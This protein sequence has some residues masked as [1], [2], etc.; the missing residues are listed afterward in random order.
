[1]T[2]HQLQEQLL[3]AEIPAPAG[4]WEQ[5]NHVLDEDAGDV[6]FQSKLHSSTVTVPENVW[7][8]IE[9][10][11]NWQQQDETIAVSLTAQE[12]QPPAFIWE[13]LET[14][15]N[16]STEQ[17]LAEKLLRAEAE[18]PVAVWPS[19]EKTLHSKAKV[20]P[21][22]KRISSVFRY[23]AAAV[24][25]GLIAWGAFLFLNPSSQDIAVIP[26]TPTVETPVPLN[27]TNTKP[28]ATASIEP[29]TT[30]ADANSSLI[31]Y[32]PPKKRITP[33]KQT[34]E[35][36][37]HDNNPTIASTEFAETNYLLV[38]DDKGDLI[39]VSKKLSTMDC[40][41]NSDMPVDAVTALQVK[42]CE[43]KIKKLQQRMAT[44][45]LGG[46]LDPSTLN[47]DTEK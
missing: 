40:V 25:I 35:A 6:S 26:S 16:Q 39:R 8:A 5:I 43:N 24:V 1:M 45:V 3:K 44:S 12:L 27:D 33:L 15:L 13:N 20:I 17:L 29:A 21:I 31:A 41:K 23:A 7:I 14:S 47:N 4:V 2:D 42:D 36:M 9:Q 37:S 28:S 30:K 19:I 32:N 38:V 18:A 46:V 22:G 34:E 10:E 11:L